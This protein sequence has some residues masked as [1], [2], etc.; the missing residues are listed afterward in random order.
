[1]LLKYHD[2]QTILLWLSNIGI[3]NIK[4]LAYLAF[5]LSCF[6]YPDILDFAIIGRMSMD[7]VVCE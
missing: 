2:S 4:H 6:D 3:S 1:M 5:I 7:P